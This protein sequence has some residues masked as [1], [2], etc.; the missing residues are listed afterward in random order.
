MEKHIRQQLSDLRLHNE[1]L[2][3]PK[4][5]AF[6]R[7]GY[8]QQAVVLTDNMPHLLPISNMIKAFKRYSLKRS[9]TSHQIY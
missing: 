5:R 7:G 2:R 3:K 1:D 8:L 9:T 6:T 4:L